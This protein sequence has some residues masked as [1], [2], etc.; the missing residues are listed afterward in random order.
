MAVT[1]SVASLAK[2][3]PSV[4]FETCPIRASLGTLGHKW[5]LLIVRSVAFSP[6]ASYSTILRQ[7]PGLP[8]R[9]LSRRLGELQREGLIERGRPSGR[10]PA[11]GYRLTEKGRDVI[12]I[13]T[14][15]IQYGIRHHADVVFE[16]RRPRTMGELF[17]PDESALLVGEWGRTE[18][19]R[20]PARSPSASRESWAREP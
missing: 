15:F 20:R 17:R 19:S 7:N 12:P 11:A 5:S 1:R 18:A 2:V 13:L 6:P 14:G 4:P 10:R 9:V 16:D 3:R 8:R